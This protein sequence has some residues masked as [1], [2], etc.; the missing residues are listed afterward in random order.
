MSTMYLHRE[1]GRCRKPLHSMPSTSNNMQPLNHVEDAAK[2]TGVPCETVQLEHDHPYKAIIAT[3]KNKS[4]DLIV[5][6]SHGRS[7]ISAVLLGSVML[8]HTNIPVLA[9]H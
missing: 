4:C 8:T 9:C 2:A 6:A 5:M 1:Y 7:G 3:A